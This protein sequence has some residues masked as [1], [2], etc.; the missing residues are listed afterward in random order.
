MV[1]LSSSTKSTVI[2][3]LATRRRFC[4]DMKAD[5]MNNPF[6]NAATVQAWDNEIRHILNAAQELGV[7]QEV[8]HR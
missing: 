2:L 3:A 1:A 7:H 6:M 4:E 8:D 5:A